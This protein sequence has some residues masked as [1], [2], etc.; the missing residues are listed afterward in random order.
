MSRKRHAP[1]N[2][3]NSKRRMGSK[4]KQARALNL[5]LAGHKYSEIASIVGYSSSGAAYNAVNKALMDSVEEPAEKVR[6]MELRRLDTMWQA[7]WSVV[8]DP[9][10]NINI[11]EAPDPDDFPKDSLYKMV[12]GSWEEK[13]LK[14]FDTLLKV[15]KRRAELLGLDAPRKTEG[16][17]EISGSGGGP[18]QSTTTITIDPAALSGEKI[19]Q[20]LSQLPEQTDEG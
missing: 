18:I 2:G 9:E 16:K 3:K 17:Q 6:R 7:L 20:L 5:R 4:Q 13:R 11:G 14:A 10:S 8:N 19:D 15:Q 1:G 12:R